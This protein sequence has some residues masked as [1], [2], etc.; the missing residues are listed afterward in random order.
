MPYES[1]SE[2]GV[3]VNKT[4]VC[5]GYARAFD[6]CMRLLGIQDIIVT[7]TAD[8]G[9]TSGSHAWNAVCLDGNWYQVDVTWDDPITSDG[10]D[11]VSYSYFNVTDSVMR[12]EHTYTC[13]VSCTSTEYWYLKMLAESSDPSVCTSVEEAE[14]YIGSMLRN[15]SREITLKYISLEGNVQGAVENLKSLDFTGII[16]QNVTGNIS[17]ISTSYAVT[18]DYEAEIKYSFEFY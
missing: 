10:S 12:K 18:G 6:L 11:V 8:N 2:Y 16:T 5:E 14:A 15:G 7:G 4:A 13:S 9:Q 1:Y 3:F 17:G